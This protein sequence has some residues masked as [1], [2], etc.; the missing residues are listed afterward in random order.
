MCNFAHVM[1]TTIEI[2]NLNTG[3]KI[4]GEN[5]IISSGLS[6]KLY[7]SNLTCLLGPNGSG[8]S[9]LINILTDNLRLPAII[10]RRHHGN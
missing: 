10:R 5:K 6:A 1:N 9:T 3:Y 4:K 8:K 7:G 2:S